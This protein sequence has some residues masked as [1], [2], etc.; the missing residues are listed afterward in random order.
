M[1]ALSKNSLHN[2][3][4][5]RK[6][7]VVEGMTDEIGECRTGGQSVAPESQRDGAKAEQTEARFTAPALSLPDH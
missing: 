4:L 7:V 6:V 3:A 1:V 5:T 2:V